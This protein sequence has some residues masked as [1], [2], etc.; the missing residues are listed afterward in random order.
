M[1]APMI[2]RSLDDLH[3][4]RTLSRRGFRVE[5]IARGD[6]AEWGLVDGALQ[7]HSRGFFSVI[8]IRSDETST[9][10]KVLLYQ[11][12]AAITG[13][14][15]SFH[16]GEQY[17][18]IQARAEPGCVDEVQFGPTIQSTPANF[19]RLHGGAGSPYSDAFIGFD[20]AVTIVSDTTQ[21]DLGERYLMKCKRLIVAEYKGELTAKPGFVWASATAIRQ[22]IS[23]STFINIDL[24][25]LLSLSPWRPASGE[26]T[27]SP[28]NSM[29]RKSLKRQVRA[30][31]LGKIFEKT[32]PRTA[33]LT[34]VPLEQLSNWAITD[35]GLYE[36]ENEQGFAVEFFNV[37]ASLREKSSWSQPLVNSIGPGY[38]GLACRETGEGLEVQVQLARE[39]GLAL[40][41]GLAPTRLFY[42]GSGGADGPAA[43]EPA[44]DK[45]LSTMESDEGG[46][47]FKDASTYEL[48]TPE[49]GADDLPDRYW[50]NLAELKL[51]LNMSNIC[52]IQLRGLASHILAL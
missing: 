33:G 30:H 38:C 21:S 48:Y 8:G 2:A 50:I 22:A 51:L 46:R 27:L 25:G 16:D 34:P 15:Y 24:R 29:A 35:R 44:G 26:K 13:L 36:N 17:F 10:G 23:Q 19:M 39:T 52:T 42:P 49:S 11:P 31:V 18:L 41:W 3:H 6:V 37:Q 47:F 28:R 9:R 14:L 12:Q 43:A 20:P 32:T 1:A 4:V 7:H 45:L 40:G 5:K